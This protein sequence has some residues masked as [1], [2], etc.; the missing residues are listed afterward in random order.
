VSPAS[1]PARERHGRRRGPRLVSTLVGAGLLVVVGFALGVVGGLLLEEPDLLFDYLTGRTTTVQLEEGPAPDVATPPPPA[2]PA[3]SAPPGPPPLAIPAAPAA[4]AAP[5]PPPASVQAA[6]P[7][8]AAA[9]AQTAPPPP[10]AAPSRSPAADTRPSSSPL[11]AGAASAAGFAVQVGAFADAGGAEQLARR[12]RSQGLPVY[13]APA[14]GGDAARWRVRVGPVPTR[15]Q[16]EQIAR[17][18]ER[19]ERLA[20]WVLAEAPH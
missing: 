13:I 12:L 11:P 10:G 1:G 8:A 14:T 3:P 6:A 18:L 7:P 5:A 20:T 19:D 15:D 4:P 17:R 16:A 2:A 9:R